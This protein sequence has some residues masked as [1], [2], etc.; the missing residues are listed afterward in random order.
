MNPHPDTALRAMTDDGSFRVITAS[1]TETVRGVIAAQRARGD[2]ARA[3]GDLVTGTILIRETMA[4]DQRVQG[5]VH[6]KGGRL[7]ADSQPDGGARGLLQ[8][9]AGGGSFSVAPDALLTMMRTL[10]SGALHSGVVQM[11]ATGGLSAALMAYLQTSEQVVSM[12]ATGTLLRDD[13]VVAAG[14][15]LVQLL[16]ELAEGPLMVMTERIREFESIDTLLKGPE[17]TPESMLE[18]LLYAMPFTRLSSSPLRFQCRCSD[19]RLLMSLST[20]PRADL[21]ELVRQGEPLEVTCEYCGVRYELT[22]ER[23]RGLLA[24]S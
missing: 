24:K 19:T 21:E 15:Y 18:E 11:P 3:L 23:L 14:G 7:V 20:L 16:P 10:P 17:T 6:S 4:P 13:E 5:I 22:P 2:A 9:P 12:I 1:T 8:P